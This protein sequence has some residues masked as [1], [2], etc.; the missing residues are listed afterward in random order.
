MLKNNKKTI[1][2]SMLKR[3][4]AICK[5]LM[6]EKDLAKNSKERFLVFLLQ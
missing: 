4:L 3:F 2:F 1:N 6:F 5:S